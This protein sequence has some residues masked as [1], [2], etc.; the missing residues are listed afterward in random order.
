MLDDDDIL[1]VFVFTAAAVVSCED[2]DCLLRPES[3]LLVTTLPPTFCLAALGGEI[4][5]LA[6]TLLS[7][8]DPVAD[9]VFFS[10]FLPATLLSVLVISQDG[11]YDG[12]LCQYV[13]DSDDE[14][15]ECQVCRMKNSLT[16]PE[17]SSSPGCVQS[18]LL[19]SVVIDPEC[20]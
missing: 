10:R 1:L 11:R 2:E 6:V 20:E 16:Q 7:G 14:G 17:F 8:E 12:L 4:F 9:E 15:G 19:S 5:L 3:T 13:Q 18:R